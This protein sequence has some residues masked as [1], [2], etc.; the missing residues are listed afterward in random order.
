[1]LV[2]ANTPQPIIDRLHAES[3]KALKLPEVQ[4]KLAAQG[5]EPMPLTPHEFDAMMAKEVVQNLELA[6]VAG[7]KAN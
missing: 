3:E 4:S 5:V 6:K 2:R 1:M 7:L